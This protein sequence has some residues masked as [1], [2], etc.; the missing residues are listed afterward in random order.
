MRRRLAC[1]AA[2][3]LAGLALAEAAFRQPDRDVTFT[4]EIAD[5]QTAAAKAVVARIEFDS[6]IGSSRPMNSTSVVSLNRPM[7]VFTM[8]GIEILSACGKTISCMDFQ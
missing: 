3:L 1:I 7:K 6:P 5:G 4:V 8:P 2:G